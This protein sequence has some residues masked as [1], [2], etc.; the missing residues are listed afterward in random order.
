MP[1]PWSELPY[2]RSPVAGGVRERV[3]PRQIGVLTRSVAP[4]QRARPAGRPITP[5]ASRESRLTARSSRSE[6]LKKKSPG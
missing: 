6:A 3:I 2:G 5:S 1:C 4:S